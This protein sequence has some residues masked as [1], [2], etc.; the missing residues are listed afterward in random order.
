MLAILQRQKFRDGIPA[1]LPRGTVVANKTGSITGIAHDCAIV[2]P[3]N[4]N[5]AASQKKSANTRKPY[6][7]VVLTSGIQD[8]K[9]GQRA[10]AAISQEIYRG[11][12]TWL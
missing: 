9:T 1:G 11:L 12:I 5:N 8:E 6:L 7:L 4:Q 2:F 10:I 3:E